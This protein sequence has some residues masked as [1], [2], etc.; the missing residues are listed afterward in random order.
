[1]EHSNKDLWMADRD[2]HSAISVITEQLLQ[3]KL[4][5]TD[6]E[7]LARSLHQAGERLQFLDSL[8]KDQE[9][10]QRVAA[11]LHDQT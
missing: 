6:I 3:L 4:S 1:M 9:G 5:A 2:L 7:D 8:I 11:I 10:Y